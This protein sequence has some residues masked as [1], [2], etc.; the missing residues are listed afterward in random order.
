[1]RRHF[2]SLCPRRRS[3]DVEDE[4][5]DR[6]VKTFFVPMAEEQAK[7]YGDYEYMARGSPPSRA[8]AR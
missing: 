2:R 7:R 1:L 3:R 8:V 5:P 4:L 6:T